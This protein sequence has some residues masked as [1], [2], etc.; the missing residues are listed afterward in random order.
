MLITCTCM[1]F[2]KFLIYF[3][4]SEGFATYLRYVR[5]LDFFETPD[6]EYLRRLF[7]D[8]MEKMSYES[9]WQFDWVGRQMVCLFCLCYLL[10]SLKN[11]TPIS[12]F[13]HIFHCYFF[14]T[15]LFVYC[16]GVYILQQVWMRQ[17]W[18]TIVFR[19]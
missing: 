5:R 10:I 6:Y 13:F 2:W 16:S 11:V 12:L 3:V 1:K 14:L 15:S 9:D 7:T 4:S 17:K 8:L 18:K 19:I